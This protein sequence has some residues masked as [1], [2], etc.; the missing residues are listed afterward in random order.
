MKIG[1]ISINMY[2]K[3]LN[4]ACPL[5][6]FAFQQFLLKKGYKSTVINYQPIY[7]NGFDMEHPYTYYKNCLKKLKKDNPLKVKKIKDYEQKKNDFKKIYKE[8]EI[9]YNKFQDF[10]DNNYLKTEKCYNSAS[11]EVESLDFDCYICVTDVIWKN[12]PHE[13]FDRG[14]FLGSSCMENKLKISYSASRGV[15][16]AKTE[17]EQKQFFKY[18]NDI[19]CISVREESLKRYIEENSNKKANVVLDPVLLHNE[20]FWNKYIKKPKEKEYLFLYYVVEKATDT[21]E[22]AIKFAE[23][24]NL[25]IIEVTDRPLKYGRVPKNSKVKHKYLYDI[26]LE[27]WLG[28]I[29]YA[30]YI[31]TNSFHGCCFSIIFKKNFFVG[32]RNGDK[33]THL[34]EMFNLSNRYFNNNL[35]VLSSNPSIDY[36]NVYKILDEKKSISENFIIEALNKKVRKEKDYSKDKKNQRYKMIYISKKRSS[37]ND[38]VNNIESYEVEEK[39]LNNGENPLLPNMF[40]SNKYIFSHWIIYILIDKDWFYYTKDKNLIN[41]K[42]YK[43]EE[44]YRFSSNDFIPYFPVNGIK[45]VVAEAIWESN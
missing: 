3:Y 38:K 21:I 45:K 34:L 11:L 35:E 27:E 28:Y 29:K 15:N 41:V 16:F 40:K 44:L 24:N 37:L 32:K 33:V 23:N 31:F 7:F 19:D 20:D 9:R 26:G 17:E 30:S 8:R 42:D 6:T 39:Q 12:E 4:F 2:S 13:G 10:I 5:H 14:F 1:I 25:T 18:I 36:D 43:E 22:E